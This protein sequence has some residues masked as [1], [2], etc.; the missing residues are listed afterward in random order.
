MDKKPLIGVSICAV[1]LLV[2]VSLTNVVG[3]QTVLSSK[4]KTIS[5]VV[6]QKELLFQ[7]IVDIAN[8]KEIQG[9]ILKYQL[10]KEDFF[11]RNL[12]FSIVNNPLI[13]KNHLKQMYF[14]SLMLSKTISKSSI[15]SILEKYQ[16]KEVIKEISQVIEKDDK[17]KGEITQLSNVKCNCEI[18]NTALFW[19]PTLCLLM[20]PV[21][22][23]L[24]Y[25]CSLFGVDMIFIIAYERWQEIGLVLNCFWARI[26]IP[27]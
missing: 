7:T 25:F 24:Y 21:F 12:K 17:I 8:N 1:V 27:T 19:H 11:H 22:L 10:S 9:I 23:A 4:Q 2:L 18:E 16:I 15:Y 26:P 13:T 20:L 5:S 6:D 14:I 3:Y